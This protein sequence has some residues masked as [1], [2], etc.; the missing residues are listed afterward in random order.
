VRRS[1]ITYLNLKGH[2][3]KNQFPSLVQFRWSCSSRR[4]WCGAAQQITGA[5]ASFP[6]PLT[7]LLTTTKRLAFSELPI[8][9][10]GAGIKQIDS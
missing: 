8:C 1:E 4:R 10:P 5:G 6:A 9:W 2:L 3:M 7:R